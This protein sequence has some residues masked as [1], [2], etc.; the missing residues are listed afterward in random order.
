MANNWGPW[1]AAHRSNKAHERH[2]ATLNKLAA[3]K[4]KPGEF[5]SPTGGRFK[6]PASYQERRKGGTL[7]H[8]PPVASREQ[9]RSRMTK[10]YGKP[11]PPPRTDPRRGRG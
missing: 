8:R 1:N 11:W 4:P 2:A 10:M 7:I 3:R 5:R 9:I 6:P